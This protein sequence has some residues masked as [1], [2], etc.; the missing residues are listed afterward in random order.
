MPILASGVFVCYSLCTGREGQLLVL[1]VRVSV[2]LDDVLA[3][4]GINEGYYERGG[5]ICKL[6]I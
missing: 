5:F 4:M 1:L 3:E 2:G 6:P